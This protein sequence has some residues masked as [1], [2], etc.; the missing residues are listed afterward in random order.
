MEKAV[1]DAWTK[2]QA[3]VQ[4]GLYNFDLRLQDNMQQENIQT[5]RKRQ[6]KREGGPRYNSADTQVADRGGV[7][8][9]RGGSRGN[10]MAEQLVQVEF[11][12]G[13]RV[14]VLEDQEQVKGAFQRGCDVK[15]QVRSFPAVFAL[16]RSLALYRLIT[17]S[18]SR[19][20][21]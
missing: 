3:S 21:Q 6:I 17:S 19:M 9:R 15:W 12:R 2:D 5:K 16:Y 11:K 13:D 20:T 7:G 1:E 18:A 8:G 10:S 14:R 4:L